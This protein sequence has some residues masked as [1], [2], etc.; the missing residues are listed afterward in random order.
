MNVHPEDW[1]LNYELLVII[2]CRYRFINCNKCTTLVGD[3][4]DE[5]AEERWEIFVFSSQFCCELKTALENYL[6]NLQMFKSQN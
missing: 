3:S 2:I 6:Q 5:W 4:N 1:I